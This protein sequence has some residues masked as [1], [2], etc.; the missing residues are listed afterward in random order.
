MTDNDIDIDIDIDFVYINVL[1][2]PAM[3]CF[4]ILSHEDFYPDLGI[5]ASRH[6]AVILGLG[7]KTRFLQSPADQ[8]ENYAEYNPGNFEKYKLYAFCS[9]VYKIQLQLKHIL[10][11]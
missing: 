8:G 1:Y 3:I 9:K 10:E 5:E 2:L 4:S 11:Q 6:T 7:L